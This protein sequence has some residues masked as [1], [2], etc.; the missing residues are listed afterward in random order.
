MLQHIWQNGVIKHWDIVKFKE[1]NQD[2]ILFYKSLGTC[3][4]PNN[5]CTQEI[6]KNL[7]SPILTCNHPIIYI[8]SG[9]DTMT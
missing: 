3:R 6:L 2:F 4:N 1:I 7:K 9:M 8:M 5:K